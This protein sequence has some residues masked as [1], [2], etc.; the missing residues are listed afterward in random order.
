M[1]PVSV[2]PGYPQPAFDYLKD[3]PPESVGIYYIYSWDNTQLYP[4]PS[5]LCPEYSSTLQ[6]P[7][8]TVSANFHFWQKRQADLPSIEPAST[9]ALLPATNPTA[10][11]KPHKSPLGSTVS[12]RGNSINGRK[13]PGPIPASATPITVH[14]DSEGVDWLTFTYTRARIHTTYCIRCD[15]ANVSLHLLPSAFCAA[16][17]IYPRAC[18]PPDQY[19]GNRQRYE[20]ECNAIGWC[21]AWINAELRGQRGLLQRAV[22]SWR[23][24]NADPTMR[25]RRV[26]KILRKMRTVS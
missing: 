15:I 25:S 6:T 9:P 2:A 13:L 14:C 7:E 16:N 10:A 23:N 5:R 8:T 26:R 11:E 3:V 17:C 19:V 22:D 20:T 21:L 12:T 4:Q 1:M 18:V 24:T